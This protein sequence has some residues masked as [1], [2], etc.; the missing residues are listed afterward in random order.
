MWFPQTYVFLRTCLYTWMCKGWCT[1]QS[2][3]LSRHDRDRHVGNGTSR[4]LSIHLCARD[5]SVSLIFDFTPDSLKTPVSQ[6]LLIPFWRYRAWIIGCEMT[7]P[8]SLRNLD[9]NQLLYSVSSFSDRSRC[10]SG[11]ILTLTPPNWPQMELGY[12]QF[13]ERYLKDTQF[14]YNIIWIWA[15]KSVSV[16]FP[17]THRPSCVFSPAQPLNEWGRTAAFYTRMLYYFLRNFI[18]S[19]LGLISFVYQDFWQHVS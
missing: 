18:M 9:S 10:W 6:G 1:Q 2:R 3:A 4:P 13:R 14:C 11:I 15:P 8:R 19:A 5:D 7:C 12:T 17:D 16:I